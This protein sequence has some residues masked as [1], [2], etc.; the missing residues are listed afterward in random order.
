[1]TTLSWADNSYRPPSFQTDSGKAV[2]VDFKNATYDIEYD[3]EKKQV[4]V[5]ADIQLDLPEDGMPIFDSIAN[6]TKVTINGNRVRQKLVETPGKETQVRVVQ[7]QLPAGSYRLQVELPMDQEYLGINNIKFGKRT[8]NNKFS[9]SDSEDR[10]Y[11]ELY[12]PS[13]LEYDQVPMTLNIQLKGKSEPHQIYSN[14]QVGKVNSKKFSVSFPDSYTSSSLFF[15]LVDSN[16]VRE[17]TF[18]YRSKNGRKIPII[19][20]Q[21]KSWPNGDVIDSE[22]SARMLKEAMQIAIATMEEL[23]KNFG[24]YPHNSFLMK[25][26]GEDSGMEH[27]GAAITGVKAVRHEL[28]H[29][30][31][32]RGYLPANGNAGWIDEALTNWAENGYKSRDSFKDEDARVLAA[33]PIYTRHHHEGGYS[34]GEAFVEYLHGKLS[35]KGGLVPFLRHL[36]GTKKLKTLTTEEFIEEMNSYYGED[37]TPEFRRVVYAQDPISL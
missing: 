25:V 9:M 21:E 23:E 5:I 2:F 3:L 7:S 12:L 10:G 8:V 4:R 17:L 22:T 15:H 26:E 31:F 6:P 30:Y 19:A 18:E 14:G 34:Q 11:L 36:V 24:A 35:G 28:I 33:Q 20:Y 16:Q 1:M 32:G 27:C 29:S 37:L 13:N